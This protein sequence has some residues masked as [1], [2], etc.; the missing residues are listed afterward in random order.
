[1]S[2]ILLGLAFLAGG[3]DPDPF[4]LAINLLYNPAFLPRAELP[5]D[6]YA[7]PAPAATRSEVA[8]GWFPEGATAAALD[9]T[10]VA[11]PPYSLRFDAPGRGGAVV[12]YAH[13]VPPGAFVAA[14]AK[15]MAEGDLR[16]ARIALRWFMADG[17]LRRSASEPPGKERDFAEVRLSARPPEGALAVALAFEAAGD[18]RACRFDAPVLALVGP[19]I[20][21]VPFPA[22]CHP[23]GVREALVKT[24]LPLLAPTARIAWDDGGKALEVHPLR[25]HPSGFYHYIVDFGIIDRIAPYT[26][27]ARDEAI[28]GPTARCRT[29]ILAA[30]YEAAG[31]KAAAYVLR[32]FTPARLRAGGVRAAAENLVLLS[33]VEAPSASV[34]ARVAELG[35]A[36]L[37]RLADAR[38]LA[39][40]DAAFCAWALAAAGADDPARAARARSLLRAA[41][42]RPAPETTPARAALCAA[43]SLLAARDNDPLDRDCADD[44]A[45]ALTRAQLPSGFF[46][47]PDDAVEQ[48]WPA[49]ALA[50][51]AGLFPDSP[52]APRVGE[53]LDAC[54]AGVEQLCLSTPFGCVAAAG[55][56][57]IPSW[58]AGTT[59][60]LLSQ[61]VSMCAH[62]RAEAAAR[63]AMHAERQ[64]QFVLGFNPLGRALDLEK[65]ESL[66][67]SAGERLR[68]GE[69]M[70][71]ENVD[72]L[73]ANLYLMHVTATLA[74][75]LAEAERL[76]REYERKR[77]ER[78]T[79]GR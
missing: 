19:A 63:L 36:L 56:T 74:A 16:G 24:H 57:E 78:Q 26:L 4:A 58:R 1:M 41:W 33:G 37:A 77:A 18:L 32:T 50:V 47:F 65:A 38:D 29:E 68:P 6:A 22:G 7:G 15:I 14:R 10:I 54:A 39:A 64:V 61:A 25:P 40:A 43:A 5:G 52:V 75:R 73:R 45:V 9:A 46:P 35:A 72:P 48:H 71:G 76:W 60:Y 21:I 8:P 34:R 51:Y 42:D 66:R 67:S 27:V 17:S 53:A 55:G 20:E 23:R 2:V 44:M 13:T 30:P 69:V 28:E 79:S 62:P 3:S 31:A 49:L 59:L 11:D 12:S 70:L